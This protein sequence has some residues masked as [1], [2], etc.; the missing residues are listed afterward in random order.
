MSRSHT[1]HRHICD[2]AALAE[3]KCFEL[4]RQCTHHFVVHK[5]TPSEIEYTQPGQLREAGAENV[6]STSNT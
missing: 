5:G 2:A 6:A 1:R 4:Q 3:V